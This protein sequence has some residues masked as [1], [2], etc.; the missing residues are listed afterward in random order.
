MRHKKDIRRLN[1]NKGQ[2]KALMRNMAISFFQ[3]KQ[4]ETTE[5]KAK[6]LSRIVE[7][8]ITMGKKNDIA[9]YR[10]INSFL[11]HPQ[12]LKN[13]KE[14]VEQYKDKNGGYTQIIKT[15]HRKGDNSGMSIIK[16]V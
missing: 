14:L 3:Y 4:L 15:N 16:L 9:S 1:R 10:R 6:Q 8:F 13:I 5:V 12:S 2:R 11:N 7:K